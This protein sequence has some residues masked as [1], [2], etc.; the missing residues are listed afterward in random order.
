MPEVGAI[1]PARAREARAG[2]VPA[3]VL[4]AA[5]VLALI[6]LASGL[7][8]ATGS[9]LHN[10]TDLLA[11]LSAPGTP[12]TWIGVHLA[13]TDEL[14]RDVLLRSLMGSAISFGVALA[15]VLGGCLIGILIGI[16]SGYR[17]QLEGVPRILKV[18]PADAM[19]P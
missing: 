2:A 16:F 8:A 11:R 3:S 13:G 6:A 7:Y 12:S 19:R 14:G 1:T 10:R 5:V 4:V 17:M 15:G 18:A 9:D